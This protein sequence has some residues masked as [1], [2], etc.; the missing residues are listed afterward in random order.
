MGMCN[1]VDSQLAPQL[2]ASV[3]SV[4]TVDVED[5]HSLVHRDLGAGEIPLT[6]HLVTG[7]RLL[8]ELFGRCGVRGTFFFTGP[9]AVAFPDLVRE[10]AAAGHE[11]ACHGWAHRPTWT[12]TPETFREDL[13][14]AR[15]A[16]EDVVGTAVQGYRAPFFSIG[17]AELWALDIVAELGFVYD[18][19]LSPLRFA[20][21]GLELAPGL[22]R[23]PEGSA[24]AGLVELPM[25]TAR[26]LGK[27]RN[28][29][30]GR[31]FRSLPRRVILDGFRDLNARGLIAQTYTHSYE[32]LPYRLVVPRPLK[33]A[34]L[35]A[36]A[37]LYE[38]AY[39]ARRHETAPRLSALLESCERWAPLADVVTSFLAHET[40]NGAS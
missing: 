40:P 26:W 15:A 6:D 9:S 23:L 18:S 1:D 29:A 21:A 5:W 37:W 33:G 24:G 3:A 13:T 7:T 4:A 17:P 30:G 22:Q 31:W 34:T 27:Q 14:R 2:A 19:S 35:R 32:V 25:T 11:V 38:L 20:A 8:V 10:V 28:I 39:A 16:L 12:F 36:K